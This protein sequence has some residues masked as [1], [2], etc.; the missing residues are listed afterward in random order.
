[1]PFHRTFLLA[2]ARC[3]AGQGQ[4]EFKLQASHRPDASP[5]LL[6]GKAR[7]E[8]TSI[9]KQRRMDSSANFHSMT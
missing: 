8:S 5:S 6:I 4:D 2:A 9:S 1:M 3:G 7:P